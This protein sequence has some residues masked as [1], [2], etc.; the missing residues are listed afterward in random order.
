MVALMALLLS[1]GVAFALTVDCIAGRGCVG[2]DGPD[3]LNGSDASDDMDA[4]QDDDKLFGNEGHDGMSGDSYAPTDTSAD[5]DDRVFGGP[6]FDG[7]VGYGGADLLSG[8]DN[9][10][11]ISAEENSLNKGEDTVKGG[12]GNDFIFAIDETK[13]TINCGGSTKDRVFYDKNIDTVER[14][15]IESTEPPEGEFFSAASATLQV[16]ALRER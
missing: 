4:K 8:G 6:G 13:D 14:C 11:F 7:L 12:R 10:D 16:N 2:T 9:R 3:I 15:E 5:G 1:S